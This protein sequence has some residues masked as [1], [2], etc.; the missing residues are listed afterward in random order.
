MGK[1]NWNVLVLIHF[2]HTFLDLDEHGTEADTIV[3]CYV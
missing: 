2:T 3:K 1:Y